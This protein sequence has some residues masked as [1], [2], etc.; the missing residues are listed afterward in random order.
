[1]NTDIRVEIN[2]NIFEKEKL[3]KLFGKYH[4][5]D[6]KLHLASMYGTQVYQDSDSVREDYKNE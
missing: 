3:N 6:G 1:M 4:I 5:P 2:K